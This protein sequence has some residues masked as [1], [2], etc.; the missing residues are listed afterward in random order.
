VRQTIILSNKSQVGIK[1]T[2]KFKLAPCCWCGQPTECLHIT[3]TLKCWDCR[4]K[5]IKDYQYRHRS[6]QVNKFNL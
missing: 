5:M 2:Q 4:M 6:L 3:A 1:R